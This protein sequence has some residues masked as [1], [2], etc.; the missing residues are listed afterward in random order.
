[1]KDGLWRTA[2]GS[3]LHM[4]PPLMLAL[5]LVLPRRRAFFILLTVLQTRV[6]TVLIDSRVSLDL[7]RLFTWIWNATV[8]NDPPDADEDVFVLLLLK[9]RC[10][11]SISVSFTLGGPSGI[12]M[13]PE[14]TVRKLGLSEDPVAT[15]LMAAS[16]YC[17]STGAYTKLAPDASLQHS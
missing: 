5:L 4:S 14:G 2:G 3:S 11:V 1:M 9:P 16:I 6:L 7:G 8:T 15:P 12:T 17:I 13:K 10:L